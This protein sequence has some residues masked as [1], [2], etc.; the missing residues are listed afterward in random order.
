VREFATSRNGFITNRCGNGQG[1]LI[2]L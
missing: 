2:W 1:E